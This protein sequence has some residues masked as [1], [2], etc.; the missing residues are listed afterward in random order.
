MYPARSAREHRYLALFLAAY[1]TAFTAWAAIAGNAEFIFYA[2]IVA[3]LIWFILSIDRRV[4]FSRPV[5]WSLAILGL[6]HMAGGNIDLAPRWADGEQD[7]VLYDLR[8]RPYLPRYDHVVH[9][10]GCFIA[11]IASYQI[12]APTVARRRRAG[13]VL[14]GMCAMVAMGLGAANETIEFIAT[15]FMETNVGRYENTGWDL[16]ANATG[17]LAGALV[18]RFR[19]RDIDARTRPAAG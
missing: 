6:L 3:A 7:A 4:H 11:A 13:W 17:A 19:W 10:Y 2:I 12:I 16:M 5:L 15:R 1:Y 9:A 18:L 8:A 14:A